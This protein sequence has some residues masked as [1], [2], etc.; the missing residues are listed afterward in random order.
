MREEKIDFLNE[1]IHDYLI[2]IARQGLSNE[3]A[4]EV[5]GM[6]SIANDMEFIADI[7]HRNMIPLITKKKS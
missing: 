4:D 6:I 5:Y 2:K 3:E 7:I 1:K